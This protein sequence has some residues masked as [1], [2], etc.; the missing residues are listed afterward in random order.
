M[1]HRYKDAIRECNQGLAVE[2][3]HVGVLEQRARARFESERYK[4]ALSD[5]Q[6]V[7]ASP[8]KTDETA[9]LE[10]KVRERLSGKGGANGGA[11]GGANGAAADAPSAVRKASKPP[12]YT[13]EQAAQVLRQNGSNFVCK[14]TLDGETKYVHVPFGISYLQLQQA[15]KAKWTGLHNF[16]I[17]YSDK[18]GDSV[19]ITCARDVSKAQS[20][21]LA[22]AQRVLSQRQRQGLDAQVRPLPPPRGPAARRPRRA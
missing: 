11:H 6:K 16:K 4:D 15:I 3:T 7:N 13:R 1:R 20:E 8:S 19:L 21:I 22:Y 17:Y 9:A 14:V 5:I 2:G 10:A 18:D 12:T